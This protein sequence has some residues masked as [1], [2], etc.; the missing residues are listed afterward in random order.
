[1]RPL[2][3]IILLGMAMLTGCRGGDPASDARSSEMAMGGWRTVE[4]KAAVA[5]QLNFLVFG[6][7]GG[8][9]PAQKR[10]ADAMAAYVQRKPYRFDGVLLTGDNFYTK[11]SGVDDPKWNIYFENM[12]DPRRLAFPFYATLG[13]HDYEHGKELIEPAYAAQRPTRFTMPARWYRL[14]L[15]AERPL[16]TLLMLDSN[17]TK[18]SP[19]QVQEQTRWLERELASARNAPWLIVVAHHP[20]YSNGS[21]GDGKEVQKQW[22]ALLQRHEVDF[23]L[24]GH[25][26]D[27]QHLQIEGLYTSFVISGGGGKSIRPMERDDRGPFSTSSYGFAH[28]QVTPEKAAVRF[29][30]DTGRTLH[31]FERTADGTVKVLSTVG[32]EP[33]TRPASRPATQPLI[34][35]GS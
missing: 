9:T 1:M 10:V 7:W 5:D 6:D 16:A 30:S 34:A 20:L 28:L 19:D 17:L 29:I 33:A 4:R 26:H 23:Y 31:V 27:L 25:D 2:G 8:N 13:N 32:V 12:Y 14:D 22:G 35:A 3:C 15:P 24:C 11:L 21:H 18:L